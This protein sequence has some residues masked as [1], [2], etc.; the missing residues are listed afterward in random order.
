MEFLRN[1]LKMFSPRMMMNIDEL[2][3]VHF[4][5][6]IDRPKRIRKHYE[7]VRADRKIWSV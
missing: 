7:K 6:R 2:L 4:N 1:G 5:L 3:F